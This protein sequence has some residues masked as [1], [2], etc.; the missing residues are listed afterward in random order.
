MEENGGIGG[1]F[2]READLLIDEAIDKLHGSTQSEDEM[3]FASLLLNR[4]ELNV[5]DT[6]PMLVYN[7]FNIATHP[8]IQSKLRDEVNTAVGR[9]KE[10]SPRRALSVTIPSCMYQGNFS[11]VS[12]WH[13]N[14]TDSTKGSRPQRLSCSSW[15]ASRYQHKCTDEG[16]DLLN[17][18]YRLCCADYYN[19]IESN[20]VRMGSSNRFTKHSLP[21]GCCDFRFE[22]L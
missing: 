1:Q 15:N 12:D 4:K 7:L 6:A 2:Y 21:K 9:D 13:G 17:K 11:N 5:K 10:I 18:I 8:D 20:Q 14:F 3:K 19:T 16:D 22:P